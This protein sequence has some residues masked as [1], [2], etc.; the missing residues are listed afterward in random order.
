MTEEFVAPSRMK[1]VS[2]SKVKYD[3]MANTHD[4]HTCNEAGQRIEDLTIVESQTAM[5]D[6]QHRWKHEADLVEQHPRQHL[7]NTS[8]G[9]NSSAMAA[10][11]HGG[12]DTG[13]AHREAVL[14]KVC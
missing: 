3:I 9:S 6:Q 2:V 12:R 10:S 1:Q 14:G 7:L 4:G 11:E 8:C 13:Q 5:F